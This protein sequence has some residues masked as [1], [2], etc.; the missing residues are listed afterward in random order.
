MCSLFLQTAGK[1]W[2]DKLGDLLTQFW[3]ALL[4]AALGFAAVY[5]LLP[6]ARRYPPLWGAAATGLALVALGAWLWNTELLLIETLLFYTFA[7][8]AIVFGGLMITQRNPVHAA[9]SF[10]MV[11][12]STCGLFLLQAAPFLMAATIII[13]AGAI[14]VTFLFVIMLAQQAGL[15]SADQRS[16]E[17]FLATTAGFVLVAAILCVLRASYGT[18]KLDRLIDGADQAA[19][20]KTVEEWQKIFGSDDAYFGEFHAQLYPSKVPPPGASTGLASEN[21]YHLHRALLQAELLWNAIKPPAQPPQEGDPPRGPPTPEQL[22]KLRAAFAEIKQ[23]A[24]LVRQG[25]G[26]LQPDSKAPLSS[27]SGTPANHKI[28]LDKDGKPKEQLPAENVA[29]LGKTLF[30]DYLLAVE[31][32]GTLLL[33][34]TIGAIAIAARRPEGLR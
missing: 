6:R 5:L 32:A 27:M 12:L 28:E 8:L 14:V 30:S 29:G 9:L 19:Q 31:L 11:V 18:S 2:G 7:G 4:T 25:K 23:L 17:P 20:A 24:L 16:R 21:K 3:P 33:I 22:E 15:S 13:Y 34:A 10:A 1:S 26:S